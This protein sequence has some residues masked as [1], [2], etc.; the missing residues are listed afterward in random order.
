M[1]YTKFTM[2][3]GMHTTDHK[4]TELLVAYF[5]VFF[6][7]YNFFKLSPI[8][9][10][11]VAGHFSGSPIKLWRLNTFVGGSIMFSMRQGLF[12]AQLLCFIVAVLFCMDRFIF[13]SSSHWFNYALAMRS[14]VVAEGNPNFPMATYCYLLLSLPVSLKLFATCDRI[15]FFVHMNYAC[16]IVGAFWTCVNK[17]IY[18]VFKTRCKL[19]LSININTEY[20]FSF[21]EA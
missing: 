19:F 14:C 6:C 21:I 16:K 3:I 1:P 8:H 18:G 10:L 2:S 7:F 4:T 9:P 17:T 11:I 5:L 20:L 12:L 13:P 15:I